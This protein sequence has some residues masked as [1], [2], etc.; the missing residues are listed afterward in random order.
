ME[1]RENNTHYILAPLSKKID[2]AL[3][4]DAFVGVLEEDYADIETKTKSI[5]TFII[6]T[7]QSISL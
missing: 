5:Y 4:D 7:T 3:V 6:T 1:I 2:A